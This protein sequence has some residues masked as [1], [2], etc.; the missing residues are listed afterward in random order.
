MVSN[1]NDNSML[2]YQ[3]FE[4]K[5]WAL[6][7]FNSFAYNDD[8]LYIEPPSGVY[9]GYVGTKPSIFSF[10]GQLEASFLAS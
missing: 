7:T 6:A 2:R 3:H 8:L 4:H 10:Q 9:E 1:D 5:I